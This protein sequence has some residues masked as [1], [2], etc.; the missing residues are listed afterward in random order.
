MAA[1]R[2][3]GGSCGTGR[4]GPCEQALEGLV[5]RSIGATLGQPREHRLRAL[6]KRTLDPA[7]LA[8]A[9]APLVGQS[10]RGQRGGAAITSAAGCGGRA[11]GDRG[12]RRHAGPIS[13]Q[14]R[15]NEQTIVGRGHTQCLQFIG[16]RG[17][18][19]L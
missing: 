18:F 12:T 8:V 19:E 10:G 16:P 14:N 7:D 4:R 11:Q 2:R 13:V 6:C 9:L 5:H 1:S 3:A 17:D 15:L